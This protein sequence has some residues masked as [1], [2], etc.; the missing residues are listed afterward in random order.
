[1]VD[2]S[3]GKEKGEDPLMGVL[4]WI[5]GYRDERMENKFWGEEVRSRHS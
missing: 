1:M 2:R 4:K 3:V 5:G